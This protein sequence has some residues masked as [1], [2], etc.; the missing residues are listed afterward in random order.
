[1]NPALEAFQQKTEI[2]VAATECNFHIFV[3]PWSKFTECD[4]AKDYLTKQ[5]VVQA[6]AA[7][8]AEALTV[9]IGSQERGAWDPKKAEAAL[10]AAATWTGGQDQ[11]RLPDDPVDPVRHAHLR[12]HGVRADR[13]VPGGAV[14]DEDPV[15]VDVAASHRQ[16]VVRR[17]AA[18]AGDRDGAASGDIYYGLCIPSSWRS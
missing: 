10:K 7:A 6:G 2:Q 1:V 16:R 18:A 12:D 13:G 17:D 5:A 4:K 3:G 14:P 8:G 9:K 11:D 15:Y